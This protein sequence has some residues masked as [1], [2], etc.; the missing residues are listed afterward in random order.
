VSEQDELQTIG[1]LSKEVGGL[2][3]RSAFIR[4]ELV[5]FVNAL[6]SLILDLDQRTNPV[7]YQRSGPR[8]VVLQ[9]YASKYS[10]LS[11]LLELVNE[12][13]STEKQLAYAKEK[14]AEVG[15]A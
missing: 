8:P 12:Q 7:C 13:D 14:L 2:K 11:K 5:Q 6:H 10:D 1:R 4:E 9:E 3:K 15:G